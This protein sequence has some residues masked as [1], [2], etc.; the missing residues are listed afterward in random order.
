MSG[1][2]SFAD[3]RVFPVFT[4]SYYLPLSKTA[5][6]TLVVMITAV[7]VVLVVMGLRHHCRSSV[8][9]VSDEEAKIKRSSQRISASNPIP[10]E[11]P[12]QLS[13]LFLHHY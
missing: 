4:N 9:R 8:Y 3:Y 12:G 2:I 10:P 1:L 7:V 5:V 6:V 11:V 13:S